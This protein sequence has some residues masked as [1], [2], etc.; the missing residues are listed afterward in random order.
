MRLE[1]AS[2]INK[3]VMAFLPFTRLNEVS[4]FTP[5]E[6]FAISFSKTGPCA[7]IMFSISL[8]SEYSAE[9]FT[10]DRLPDSKT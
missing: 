5:K 10:K 4:S 3:T 1:L 9:T 6:I 7:T 2:F 8:I